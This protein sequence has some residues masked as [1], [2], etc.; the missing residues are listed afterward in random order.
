VKQLF[1]RLGIS[2]FPHAHDML[3]D[4]ITISGNEILGYVKYEL[5]YEKRKQT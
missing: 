4:L 5:Y 3:K 1:L 2:S